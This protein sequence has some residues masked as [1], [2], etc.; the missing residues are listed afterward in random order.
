MIFDSV[1]YHNKVIQTHPLKEIL[2]KDKKSEQLKKRVVENHEVMSSSSDETLNH[3][4]YIGAQD[5][6]QKKDEVSS[7]DEEK[8]AEI[9][10]NW[11]GAG[12]KQD[13]K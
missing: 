10:W 7:E 5:Q 4:H 2:D 13:P 9:V 8:I 6:K 11:K 3:A 1:Y 12:K